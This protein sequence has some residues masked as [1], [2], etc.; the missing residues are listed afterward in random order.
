MYS[1]YSYAVLS[2]Q[3][4]SWQLPVAIQYHYCNLLP[5][6]TLHPVSDDGFVLKLII[7]TY[8]YISLHFLCTVKHQKTSDN[9]THVHQ[10]ISTATA[11]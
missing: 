9:K 11:S 10:Q 5:V 7:Y 1:M 2:E 4:F 8:T 3:P 6:L